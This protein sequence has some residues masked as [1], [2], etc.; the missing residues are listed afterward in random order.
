MAGSGRVYAFTMSIAA[1]FLAF[2][3]RR[4]RLLLVLA[5]LY[6]VWILAGF[7]LVPALVRPRLER[8][9]TQALKRPVTVARLR[10]N[11]F[12]FGATVEGLLNGDATRGLINE[13]SS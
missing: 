7:F 3:R 1:P 13:S 12:T 8:E 5:G 11:P 10:F 2:L 9:A 6:G 4:R